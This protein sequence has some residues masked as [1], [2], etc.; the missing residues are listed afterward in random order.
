MPDSNLAA[1]SGYDYSCLVADLTACD[2]P[3]VGTGC[4]ISGW[5]SLPG[6]SG[7]ATLRRRIRRM[8]MSRRPTLDPFQKFLSPNLRSSFMGL[9]CD[10][11]SVSLRSKFDST[12]LFTDQARQ[13]THHYTYVRV[14]QCL[15]RVAVLPARCA[16]CFS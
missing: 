1:L 14:L 5:G 6:R 12:P 2:M 8:A 13:N 15:S 9:N 4:L 7:S 16:G 10:R 11:H 3:A